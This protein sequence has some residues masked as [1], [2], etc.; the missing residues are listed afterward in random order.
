MLEAAKVDNLTL[1][2]DKSKYK[3]TTLNLLGYCISFQEVKPDQR[4]LQALLDLPSPT[5]KRELRRVIGL[6]SYYAKWIEKFSQKAVPLLHCDTIPLS[7]EAQ[8]S[9]NLLK[10]ELAQAGLGVIKDDLPF[11]VETDASDYAIAA[12][13]SQKRKPI[14][15]FSRTLNH[16]ERNY[17]TVEKEAT[18]IIEAVRK[19]SH[20]LKGR[21]F[22]LFTDQK[23]ISFMFDHNS[24]GKIKNNKI[25][26]WRLELSQYSYDI[27]HKPGKDHVAPDALSRIIC[28]STP[29][30]LKV[31]D[32]HNNLGHPGFSRL[33]NFIRSRNL[34]FTSEEVKE[35]C[36][37][38]QTCAQIKPRFFK[39]EKGLLIKAT[40]PFERLSIDF[41]GPLKG[42][43]PYLL[44]MIDEFSRFPFAFPCRDMTAKTV[45]ECLSNVFCVFGFPAY[46]HSDRGTSFI[47]RD[48]KNF[49]VERGI[50]SSYTT[51]YHP[52][53]NGQCE[54]AVQTV[55]R[56][57]KLILHE[58]TL[59]EERYE[60]VL[61]QALHA[62]RS[63][64]CLA[65]NETPHERLFAFPR[66]AS[67]G[68]SMPSW[69]LNEGPVLLRRFVRSK[70]DPL[71]DQVYL[72]DANPMHARI[73]LPDGRESTVSTSDLAPSLKH[74]NDDVVT[75]RCHVPLNESG[76]NEDLNLDRSFSSEK[77]SESVVDDSASLNC[78]RDVDEASDFMPRR[79]TRCRRS[80]DRYSEWVK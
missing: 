13:L 34:P 28:S 17:S 67:T 36:Q 55:W 70:N 68:T 35:T 74:V 23:A 39:P 65:T 30:K 25:L 14:A 58:R 79:S 60:V 64:L 42:P 26:S 19:W 49:L 33:Y 71:C 9:F 5:T 20:F 22:A 38:C 41:K 18:A 75:E 31:M 32:L 2:E 43:R 47:S 61:P 4:R 1:N 76:I 48:V 44:I 8:K 6:F 27:S 51:P 77:H 69:L 56:T 50:A 12:I 57:V 24:R 40:K 78:E 45:I 16:C 3:V 10:S 11:E 54:R 73:R 62:I 59:P 80:P 53:G 37:L 7:D 72:L 21:H 15:Y 46:I 52:R 29:S 63:L 66:R